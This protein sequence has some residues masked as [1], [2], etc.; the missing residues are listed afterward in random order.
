MKES[1]RW[2]IAGS[3]LLSPNW[4]LKASLDIKRALNCQP[5][6]RMQTALV[7]F[8]QVQ[9]MFNSNVQLPP[10]LA[11]Q[12][13]SCIFDNGES[14]SAVL[15]RIRELH[16]CSSANGFSI[17]FINYDRLR[18]WAKRLAWSLSLPSIMVKTSWSMSINDTRPGIWFSLSAVKRVGRSAKGRGLH[19]SFI[20]VF[21]LP[22]MLCL[23]ENSAKSRLR[24]CRSVPNSKTLS[25]DLQ[26]RK[27]G[28]ESVA[29]IK[30]ALQCLRGALL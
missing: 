6:N 2:P 19:N 10:S 20:I 7:C 12:Q 5:P 13:S 16:W 25:E 14:S 11:V 3:R 8:K 28:L 17:R 22:M 23:A 30:C 26:Q 9:K 21:L 4:G 15:K 18:N 27:P 29:K 24:L 1:G